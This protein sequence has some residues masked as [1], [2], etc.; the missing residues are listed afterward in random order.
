[1]LI[2]AATLDTSTTLEQNESVAQRFPHAQLVVLRN[3]GHPPGVFAG[4]VPDIYARFL[5]TLRVGDTSCVR[6]DDPDRPAV[7][8]F[9]RRIADAPPA[10][11]HTR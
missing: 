1:M 8:V 3:G 5:R 10:K 7:G 11:P 2:I 4:C 9:A 6:R